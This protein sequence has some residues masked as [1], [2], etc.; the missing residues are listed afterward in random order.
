MIMLSFDVTPF[1]AALKDLD[2]QFVKI[3][4]KIQT[5][6]ENELLF[7]H[8]LAKASMIGA[9]TR[10]ENALLTDQ[11]VNWLDTLLETSPNVRAFEENRSL[12]ENK[13][14]KDRER[15][16]EE[17]TGCRQM[18]QILFEQYSQMKPFRETDLRGL[19]YALMSPYSQAG[20][21][22]GQYKVQPNYVV[23]Y[24]NVTKQSKVVFK[25]A[26]A[27]PITQAAMSDLIIWYEIAIEKEPWPLAIASELVFRFL[28]IHP[29]QDGN[30]RLGRGLFMLALL[31]SNQESMK[32]IIPLIAIDRH[33]EKHKEE[34]YF[35]LNRCSD[36]IYQPD[37]K[38]YK[39]QYFL[40][41]MIKIV[42]ETLEDI[43]IYHQRFMNI[44]KLSEAASIIYDCFKN[45]PEMRL[46]NK[47]IA[48]QTNISKRTIAYGLNQLL[49]YKLIQKYGQGAGTRYQITF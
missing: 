2:N 26:E 41:F 24:N 39:I 8:K 14:S 25:T 18:L 4:G 20:P 15:S 49:E 21:F 48:E 23:E 27:G 44:Q 43:E 19:H 47:K 6:S 29:F 7:I 37:P 3:Y 35:T 36:G 32:S 45:Y 13:L 38:Q 31:Q 5:F 11:E 30:G 12:I 42:R 17:V 28:A 9:S 1:T 34:Y 46:T 16:Y 22:I 33:I 40:N 10:I